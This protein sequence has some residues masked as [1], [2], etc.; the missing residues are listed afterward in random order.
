MLQPWFSS[1]THFSLEAN[2]GDNPAKPFSFDIAKCPQL[3]FP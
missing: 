2:F 3:V 1:Y